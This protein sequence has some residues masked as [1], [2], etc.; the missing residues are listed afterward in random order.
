MGKVHIIIKLMQVIILFT[1]IIS[2]IYAILIPTFFPNYRTY[3][4]LILGMVLSAGVGGY[5]CQRQLLSQS[6]VFQYSISLIGA[7][8][9]AAVVLFLSL[10]IIVN[11][12][13]S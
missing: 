5:L 4:I 1:T 8:G 9:V 3:S 2:G 13:G 10:L 6:M 12:R 11:V 7:L